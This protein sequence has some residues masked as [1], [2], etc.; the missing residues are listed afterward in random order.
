MR[1]AAYAV[2]YVP[3]RMRGADRPPAAFALSWAMILGIALAVGGAAALLTASAA[4]PVSST[5]SPT[6]LRLSETAFQWI[7]I[8]GVL[9]VVGFMIF[10][11]VRHGSIP[12]P[13]RFIAVAA[14]AIIILTIYAVAGHFVGGGG[15]IPL[16][17]IGPG[18][19][20]TATGNATGPSANVTG[21][22]GSFLPFT[23]ALPPWALFALVA[24][25]AL[26]GTIVSL[27]VY[28][29]RAVPKN[30]ADPAPV[31]EGIRSLLVDA[32]AALETDEE[33]RGVLIRLYGLLLE[34]LTVI[35]GDTDRQTA[36]EIRASHLTRLGIG[37]GTAR[38]ITHLFEEAR[39]SQHP[40]GPTEL[41]RAKIAIREAIAE[42]D[43]G[44]AER[45]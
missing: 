19:N 30:A 38:E 6:L 20:D 25:V 33:P 4:A 24:V 27:Q 9:G 3:H 8:A 15:G 21:S 40:I 42:L 16:T 39:Y 2:R 44:G 45:M 36:E 22:G 13:T 23:F 5:N 7:A 18:S 1:K 26:V 31:D 12:Y 10:D 37:P 32:S 17:P 28:R 11:R 29:T 43:A 35:V 14:T 41:G 34:H